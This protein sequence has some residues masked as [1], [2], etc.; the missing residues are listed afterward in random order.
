MGPGAHEHSPRAVVFDPDGWSRRRVVDALSSRGDFRV[1]SVAAVTDLRGRLERAEPVDCVVVGYDGFE[2][3]GNENDEF[4]DALGFVR[5]FRRS[6]RSLPFVLYTESEE[7]LAEALLEAG[8]AGFVRLGTEDGLKRLRSRVRA[9][10]DEAKADERRRFAH[11]EAMHEF[12]LEFESCYD[13]ESAYQLAVEAAMEIL[14]GDGAALYVEED[15][16]LEPVASV[17]DLLEGRLRPYGVDEGVVGRTYRTER[18]SFNPN[19][20]VADDA[21]P[22]TADIRSGISAPVGSFGVLQTVSTKP[23]YLDDR[24]VQLIE[25]LASHVSSTIGRLESRKAAHDERDRF[26]SLFETVPDAVVLTAGDS[27]TIVDVNPGFERRFGYDCEEIVGESINDLIVPDDRE[28]L[29]VY[30][31]VG[32]DGVVTSELVRN[33]ADGPRE[34]LFRGFAT[35]IEGEVHEYAIYTDITERKRRE[36]E[37]ERYKTLIDTVGDPVYALDSEGNIEMANEAL[38]DRAGKPREELVGSHVSEFMSE[39]DVGHGT[40]LLL[41]IMAT[42]DRRWDTFEMTFDLPGRAPIIAENNVAPIVEDEKL[43]GSVGVIRDVTER[44]ERE[45]RIRALHDGTRR[46]MN[47]TDVDE[48][49]NIAT[50]I[51][52]DT[53]DLELTGVYL[54]DEDEGAL[55][56]AAVTPATRDLIG[57]PPV[58]RPNEALAWD[59]FEA[60]VPM[61]HGDVRTTERVHNSEIEIRSEAHLPLGEYG[62]LLVASTEPNDFNEA[63][64]ALANILAA[65]VEAAIERAERESELAE[66]TGELERQNDRLDQFAGTVSHDLRNPLTLAS[67]HAETALEIAE[68]PLDFHLEEISWALDRMDDLIE[69]VLALARS[70]RQLTETEPTDLNA[71]VWEANRTVDPELEVDIDGTLPTVPADENRLLVMFE[72]LFRNALEHVGEDVTITV[73]ETEDGFA[74]TDDGPGIPPEERDTVFDSGYTTDPEGTGFGLAIVMEVV[75]AHGWSISLG[76]SAEGGARFDVIVDETLQTVAHE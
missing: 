76:E 31:E 54:Y 40:R 64:L 66:R 6:H 53:L 59:A 67:G 36:R 22:L 3:L 74:V 23:G 75:D 13:R 18:P 63:A 29:V 46:L 73:S 25:L 11:L 71:L 2:R 32:V 57:E 62:L 24:D 72:N 50:E 61:A 15:G 55:V 17:G 5:E 39:E 30:D 38:V 20:P 4:G 41:E 60:G 44:K 21:S 27:E 48:V 9:V 37:L 69:D 42:D 52:V 49:A 28:P 51:A 47:A 45:R 34:F 10:I 19:I 70:G 16:E 35:E 43:V 1:E 14:G 12:A 33:T 8:V 7:D 65:N 68:E 58:F 56:P 26:A